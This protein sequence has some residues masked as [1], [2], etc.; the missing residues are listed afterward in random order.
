[1]ERE[2]DKEREREREKQEQQL[3]KKSEKSK[4][5]PSV[6]LSERDIQR[7]KEPSQ[8]K[9]MINSIQIVFILD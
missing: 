9:N 8:T 2:R 6:C 1:M 4:V 5:N 3:G 7:M